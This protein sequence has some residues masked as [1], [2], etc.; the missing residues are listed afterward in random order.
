MISAVILEPKSLGVLSWRCR[1]ILWPVAMR[2]LEAL[3]SE[4]PIIFQ[5]RVEP[6]VLMIRWFIAVTSKWRAFDCF[7]ATRDEIC[8]CVFIIR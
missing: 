2:I 8:A 4:M 1:G 6:N 3:G 7:G 5:S